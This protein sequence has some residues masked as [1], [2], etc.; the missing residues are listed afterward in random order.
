ML[1]SLLLLHH[2]SPHRLFLPLHCLRTGSYPLPQ[3]ALAL[4]LQFLRRPLL[5]S[6]EGSLP[7]SAI[8]FSFGPV[9]VYQTLP[10][11]AH[12]GRPSPPQTHNNEANASA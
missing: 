10:D 5:P 4:S 2:R 3:Q 1:L 8:R 7:P 6:L 11:T 12:E 9:S